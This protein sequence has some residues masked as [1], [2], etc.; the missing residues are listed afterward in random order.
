MCCSI[1]DLR[2]VVRLLD[3]RRMDAAVLEQLLERQPGDLAADAVEAGQQ[4]R[5]GRVVDDEVDAR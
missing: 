5:A 2:L 3:P 1:S 4:D